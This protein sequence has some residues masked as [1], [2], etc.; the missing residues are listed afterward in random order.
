MLRKILSLT[1]IAGIGMLF[2]ALD[3]PLVAA[4]GPSGTYVS[5]IACVNLSA[6]DASYSISFYNTGGSTVATVTGVVSATK[7]FGYFSPNIGGLPSSFVGSAIVSS[8]QQLGCSVNVQTAP[9]VGINRV[10]NYSGVLSAGTGPKLYAPQ[11]LNNAG[12]GFTSYFVAQNTGSNPVTATL[13]V[14]NSSGAQVQTQ[15]ATIPNNSSHIFY[16]DD[17]SLA[18]GFSGSATIESQ[19]GTT[20]LAGVVSFFNTGS[21]GGTAQFLT[22]NAFTS[23]A[24][25]VFA[26]RVVKN[27]SNQGWTSGFN[28]QN[29]GGSSTVITA[30]FTVKN[31]NNNT[32]VGAV[33]VS[34]SLNPSQSWALYMG[35]NYGTALDGVA[36]YFGGA[37][38]QAA[39][40]GSIVCTVNEDNR[41][42][43]AGQ[44]TAYNGVPD[45]QQTNSMFFPQIVSLGSTS[46]QGG[47]QILNTTGIAA[48]C[49]YTYSN[50]VV[51]PSQALAANSANSIFA[52]SQVGSTNFNGSAAVTCDQPIVGIYNLTIFGGAGDPYAAE[53]GINR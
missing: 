44:G 42:L 20:P 14:F 18:A 24:N 32:T 23:G 27:L 11:V 53:N 45:G 47:F 31:Q 33:M 34:P 30:T 6:S 29:V 10:D 4:A 52:P 5:G 8:D 21:T 28:C 41:T 36:S 17:G 16:Q 43:Y 48:T 49:V 35:N 38:A 12:G 9:G 37:T 51:V 3:I 25:K 26:P 13:K 2:L 19:D 46:Y 1:L 15:S 39:P 7:G 40:G 50:G 22:Y